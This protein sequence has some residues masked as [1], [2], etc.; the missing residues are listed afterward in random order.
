MGRSWIDRKISK[1]TLALND[2]LDQMDQM[3]TCTTF[4]LQ[5]VKYTYF[6]NAHSLGQITQQAE[7]TNKTINKFLKIE[8]M[9]SITN[10]QENK[11]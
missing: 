4:Y 5:P 1:K 3:D 8:I 2:P 11:K 6:S 9:I 10:H 7:K